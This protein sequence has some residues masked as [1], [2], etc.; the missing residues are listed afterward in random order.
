M[1]SL[2]VGGYPQVDPGFMPTPPQRRLA[3][4]LREQRQQLVAYLLSKVDAEDWHS[5]ADAAM[6][7]REIDA[8]LEVLN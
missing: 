2:D 6:D 8:K 1:S 7:L 4:K 5:C 3:D